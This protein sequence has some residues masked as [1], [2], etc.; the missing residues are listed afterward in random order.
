MLYFV[1][2][3]DA[4]LTASIPENWHAASHLGLQCWQCLF[5]LVLMRYVNVNN[6]E[7]L[8]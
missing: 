8:I 7:F 3:Y 6:H 5:V 4:I 1:R 2:P